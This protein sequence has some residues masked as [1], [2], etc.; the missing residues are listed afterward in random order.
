[1]K[2]RNWFLATLAGA[3]AT[4]GVWL[5]KDGPHWRHRTDEPGTH[6]FFSDDA[7]FFYTCHG[8]KPMPGRDFSPRII[9]WETASGQRLDEI[10]ISWNAPLPFAMEPLEVAAAPGGTRLII[11]GATGITD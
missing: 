11:C 8:L 1:M 10:P 7:S 3:I 9:R 4:V 2:L 6:P 5:W